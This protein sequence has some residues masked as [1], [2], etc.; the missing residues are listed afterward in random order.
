MD[1][2][3]VI[4]PPHAQGVF[5]TTVKSILSMS[6]SQLAKKLEIHPRQLLEYRK[7]TYSLSYKLY[8]RIMKLSKSIKEP[9]IVIRKQFWH[10]VKAGKKGGEATLKRHGAIGGND[11]HRKKQW[12]IWWRNEGSKKLHTILQK[13][14]IH[15]PAQSP[16]LA[17]IFGIL[18]G[19]GGISTY[20]VVVTLNSKSDKKYGDFVI[21]LFSRVFRIMPR[22]YNAY[23]NA[24][25][26]V[27]SRK[28]LVEFLVSNGLKRG[29]KIRENVSIPTWILDSKEYQ[30]R[31]VRGLVDTDGSVVIEKHRVGKKIYNYPRLNFTNSSPTLIKQVYDIFINQGFNPKIRR[32]GKSV[33]LE[34]IKEIC[35]YFSIIGSSNPKHM[36]RIGAWYR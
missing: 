19:D 33:Q 18:L 11:A 10:N 25:N 32:A 14:E 26:I 1:N 9:P 28:A 35:Q 36:R 4:F 5:F 2:D 13:K 7:G 16:D 8:S 27:I 12:D 20:Q 3:R 22:K 23:G 29:H 24:F 21:Q 30:K 17:E 34:N 6:W 15:E 31:C